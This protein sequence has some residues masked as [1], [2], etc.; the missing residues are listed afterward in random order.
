MYSQMLA[1]D[2]TG[3]ANTNVQGQY[4]VSRT[5]STD[6]TRWKNGSGAGTVTASPSGAFNASFPMLFG[7]NAFQIAAGTFGATQAFSSQMQRIMARINTYQT[8]IG[9][10]VY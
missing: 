7:N 9:N 2:S 1:T 8:A 10:N 6:F 4:A 3:A 5:S